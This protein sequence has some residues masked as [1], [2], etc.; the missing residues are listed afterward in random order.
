MSKSLT[1]VAKDIWSDNLNYDGLDKVLEAIASGAKQVHQRIELAALSGILGDTGQVNLHGESVQE[2]DI[3]ASDIFVESLRKSGKVAVVGCE[4]IEEA[5]VLGNQVEK[6]YMVL[7]DPMDGSSNVDVAVSVGSIFGIWPRNQ[8][9]SKKDMSL[10]AP[11]VEQVAAAYVIYG[12]STVL[13]IADHNSVQGFTLDPQ[14]GKF[15][16]THPDILIPSSCLYYSVNEGNFNKWDGIIQKNVEKLRE[17][18]SHRYVGS[19]VADFH[20]NLLKGGIFLYP[21]DSKNPAGKLR[22]MYEANPLSFIAERAG[23]KAS[24]GSQ[25][26]LD[27]QP[28]ALHERTPLFI[29]N[30][31]EIEE[32]F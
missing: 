32:Y 8:V 22:L 6:K 1:E 25:R 15:L 24:S 20:R 17:I 30:A 18:Y 3:V 11:G 13:V 9:A 31:V 19:L 7:M 10:L 14:S 26:I 21:G 12:S 28:R 2:A 5:V 16:L 4:E 29:G 23:G 27:I